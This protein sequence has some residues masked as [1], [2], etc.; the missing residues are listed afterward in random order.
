LF[1][2]KLPHP[3]PLYLFLLLFP[4]SYFC[5]LGHSMFRISVLFLSLCRLSPSAFR[6]LV[7][8][9]LTIKLRL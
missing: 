1:L 2:L 9:F 4:P 5:S 7:F 3:F 8:G 6:G